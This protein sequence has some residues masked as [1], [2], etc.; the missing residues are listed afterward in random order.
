MHKSTLECMVSAHQDYTRKQHRH[1]YTLSYTTAYSTVAVSG[2][3]KYDLPQIQCTERERAMPKRP[4]CN[5]KV[6][7]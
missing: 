6:D 1:E 5:P 3:I 4:V 2:N 7:K